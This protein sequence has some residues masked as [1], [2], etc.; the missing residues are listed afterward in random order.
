MRRNKI[1]ELWTKGKQSIRFF[2]DR[3]KQRDLESILGNVS[4]DIAWPI[5]IF[6]EGMTVTTWEKSDILE[7][8]IVLEDWDDEEFTVI[9]DAKG[10]RLCGK[11]SV[12]VIESLK[13]CH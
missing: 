13:V 10:R 5:T 3:H 4:P 12:M 8:L 9:T 2:R 11:I 1:A 6:D 7:F